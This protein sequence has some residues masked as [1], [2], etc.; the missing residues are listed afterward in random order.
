MLKKRRKKKQGQ[1]NY[2]KCIYEVWVKEKKKCLS[3]QRLGLLF[4]VPDVLRQHSEVFCGICLAF[5]CSFDEF[6]GEKVFSPSYSSAILALP[7]HLNS[8]EVFLLTAPHVSLLYCGNLNLATHF[9]YYF[10][11]NYINLNDSQGRIKNTSMSIFQQ[12]SFYTCYSF[13]KI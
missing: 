5:E 10:N 11:K 4:W 8:Y 7:P 13:L 2:K 12:N 6:V 3:F 1:K 9:L